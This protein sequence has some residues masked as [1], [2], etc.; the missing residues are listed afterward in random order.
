MD[1]NWRW[2]LL[3]W[4]FLFRTFLLFLLF[5]FT[6]FFVIFFFRGLIHAATFLLIFLA[7]IILLNQ[8]VPNVYRSYFIDSIVISGFRRVLLS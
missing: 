6:F 1:I 2:F 3:L 8:I 7:I 4:R 5:L